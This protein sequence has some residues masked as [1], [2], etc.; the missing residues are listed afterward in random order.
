MKL[1]Y[2]A[3]MYC[4]KFMTFKGTENARTRTN[5]DSNVIGKTK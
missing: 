5:T 1:E 4:R 2:M 3:I